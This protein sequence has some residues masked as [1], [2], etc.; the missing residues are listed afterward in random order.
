MRNQQRDSLVLPGEAL[1]VI[2]GNHG[3]A[4]GSKERRRPKRRSS[5]RG[6]EGLTGLLFMTPW[7]V[8]LVG[9]TLGP[10]IYSLYL[11]FTRYDLM[12][13]PEWVGVDNFNEMLADPRFISSA[14]VTVIYAVV[15]V[16]L[17]LIVS[18][19]L[20]L[21]LSRGI[22]F[23]A[24]YRVLFYLPSLL[25]ASVAVAILWRQIF[26]ADGIVNAVLGWFGIEHE[27]WIGNP[28]TALSTL[29]TLSVWAFGATMIIFLAGLLQIPK[30]LYEAA[31]IDGAGPVRR[32]FSVTVP[33]MTP[34]IFFNL[35]LDTVH[36]FDAFTSAYV[37]SGGT[38]GPSD[39]TLFYTLY[40]YI[41][42]FSQLDM[43]YAAAMAWLLVLVLAAFTGLAFFSAKYWVFYGD[44]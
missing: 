26:G 30:E 11:S 17:L 22:R 18:M 39:S 27:S 19:L 10:M 32:F 34:L 5:I 13:P 38:G 23:L 41:Q 43:G 24:G 21:L 9:L 29:I 44:E 6:R 28:D 3:A 7:L 31:S 33:V 15:S 42:G 2:K 14:R 4:E 35:L 12:S 40:L 37:V 36:A 20:A 16:P 8:G 25:G 1:S